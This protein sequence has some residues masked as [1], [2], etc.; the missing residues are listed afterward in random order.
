MPEALSTE[1]AK[2]SDAQK[3]LAGKVLSHLL[4][5]HRDFWDA[6]IAKY[7]PEGNFR[8]KYGLDDNDEDYP[9]GED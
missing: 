9:D 8:K 6:L 7:D 5:N 2:C 1:C 3:K 4:Q